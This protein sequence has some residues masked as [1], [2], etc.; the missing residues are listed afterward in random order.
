MSR[1]GVSARVTPNTITPE[2][3]ELLRYGGCWEAEMGV[4]TLNP[5]VKDMV[6]RPESH[7]QIRKA[8]H[9]L[10]GAG[11]RVVVDHIFGLP[12]QTEKDLV[13]TFHFYLPEAPSRIN[14]YWLRYFP[15]T[16]VVEPALAAGILTPDDI[17]ELEEGRGSNS[18]TTGGTKPNK[19]F[20]AHPND[21]RAASLYAALG[22]A[23]VR[24]APTLQAD[25]VDPRHRPYHHPRH[26][27]EHPAGRGGPPVLQALPVLPPPQ[28]DAAAAATDL[29]RLRP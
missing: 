15:R 5:D 12:G 18:F 27:L 4:Q 16:P 1:S 9:W 7:E 3:V 24:A 19:G 2:T 22:P 6:G 20:D 23:A 25:A 14:S 26:Q 29:A 8:I 28:D 10:K 21:V 11:I 17:E 13:D